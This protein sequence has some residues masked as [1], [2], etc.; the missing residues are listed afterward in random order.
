MVVASHQSV[1]TPQA[2]SNLVAH[3]LAGGR[4]FLLLSSGVGHPRGVVVSPDKINPGT[5]PDHRMA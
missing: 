5:A 2:P 4:R 1:P 3:G